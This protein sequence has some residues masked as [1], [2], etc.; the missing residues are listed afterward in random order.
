[1]LT[2][3]SRARSG[4]EPKRASTESREQNARH[5]SGARLAAA[6]CGLLLAWLLLAWAMPAAQAASL[7][8]QHAAGLRA[9]FRHV[10]APAKV[11]SPGRSII[12]PG[13]ENVDA[14]LAVGRD[15]RVRGTVTNSVVALAGNITLE[16]GARVRFVLDIGGHVQQLRGS[17]VS[18]A[19][20]NVGDQSPVLTL[21]ALSGLTSLGTYLAMA[22]LTAILFLILFVGGSLLYPRDARVSEYLSRHPLRCVATGTGVTLIPIA[23]TLASTLTPALWLLTA[24]FWLLYLLTGLTGLILLGNRLGR[25]VEGVWASGRMLPAPLY[26]AL[27]YTL[28]TSI[29]IAGPLAA[30]VCWLLGQG[31]VLS[32]ILRPRR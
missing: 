16:P 29:P 3:R 12:V 11:P 7:P 31:A 20:I 26:G 25:S 13:G 4:Q 32:A 30:L 28:L 21:L 9:S 1:M 24:L 14:V 18:E 2:D 17:S 22:S 23:V 10:L 27:A 8:I 6:T 5:Q 15:V 19:V